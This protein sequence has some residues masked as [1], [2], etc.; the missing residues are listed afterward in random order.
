MHNAMAYA[1]IRANIAKINDKRGLF[2]SG[3]NAKLSFR[4]AKA[5][6]DQGILV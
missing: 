4:T 1:M 3:W 6:K 2:K 5:L